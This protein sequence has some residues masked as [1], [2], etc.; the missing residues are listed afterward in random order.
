MSRTT[1]SRFLCGSPGGVADQGDRYGRNN[2]FPWRANRTARCRGHVGV[3]DLAA[4]APELDRKVAAAIPHARNVAQPLLAFA[5]DG[6]SRDW[7]EGRMPP[8][9]HRR[10]RFFEASGA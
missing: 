2:G 7:L 9:L 4:I 8:P 6:R 1:N 3:D 10:E 5:R